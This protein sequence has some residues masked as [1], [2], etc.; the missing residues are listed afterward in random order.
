MK[1]GAGEDAQKGVEEKSLKYIFGD[2]VEGDPRERES[3]ILVSFCSDL[4][5]NFLG[6]NL[7]RNLL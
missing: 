7:V 1:L 5:H 2:I 6:Q 3:Q 4:G